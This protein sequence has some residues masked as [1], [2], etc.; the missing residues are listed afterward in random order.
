MF[1]NLNEKAIFFKLKSILETFELLFVNAG[2]TRRVHITEETLQHLNGAY[3]VEDGDGESRNTHLN[4]R[5]TFLVIDP[6]KPSNVPRRPN[7]VGA[8]SFISLVAKKV[9]CK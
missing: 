5:K 8:R 3:E 2:A 6:N 7:L 9:L 1:V 4:L